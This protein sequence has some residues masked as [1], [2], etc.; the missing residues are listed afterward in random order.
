[1]NF[2]KFGPNFKPWACFCFHGRS[3]H[4]L[5]PLH[6]MLYSI[7]QQAKGEVREA[8]ERDAMLKYNC[9][10]ICSVCWVR[11]SLLSPA[12]N[13]LHFSEAKDAAGLEGILSHARAFAALEQTL[14]TWETNLPSTTPPLKSAPPLASELEPICCVE[15]LPSEPSCALL[16]TVWHPVWLLWQCDCCVQLTLAL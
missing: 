9:C 5:N 11:R 15:P 7:F 1:M 14:P 6:G 13:A 16:W 2:S 8:G 3:S 10:K 12:R 4:V